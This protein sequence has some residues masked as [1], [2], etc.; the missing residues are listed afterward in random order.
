MPKTDYMAI[1]A[2]REQDKKDYALQRRDQERYAMRQ[3][4]NARKHAAKKKKRLE[5]QRE[6]A[7]SGNGMDGAPPARGLAGV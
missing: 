4:M 7:M 6:E 5:E 2:Q 1:L 3:D